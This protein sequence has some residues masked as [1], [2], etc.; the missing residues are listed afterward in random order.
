[1]WSVLFGTANTHQAEE[2]SDDW[3]RGF[4]EAHDGSIV[5]AG[6]SYQTTLMNAAQNSEDAYVLTFQPK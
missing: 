5:L 3:T 4:E 1:V 6:Y 2:I